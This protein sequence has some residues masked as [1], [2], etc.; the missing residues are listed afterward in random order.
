MPRGSV[1]V[2]VGRGPVVDQKALYEALQDGQLSAAGLDVWYNY[3][4]NEDTRSSTPPSD[5]PFAELENV[6]MTPHRSGGGSTYDVEMLRVKHLSE[7]LNAVV[8][9]KPIPN[10]IDL[11]AGY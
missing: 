5:Y 11:Q 10:Q 3:P 2:N 7:L 8:L 4:Q 6:I 1:L 9:G